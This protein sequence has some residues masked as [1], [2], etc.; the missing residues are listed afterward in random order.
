MTSPSPT[1]SSIRFSDRITRRA[2]SARP[3]QQT[4]WGERNA[5]VELIGDHVSH[6]A[7]EIGDHVAD[8][9][10]DLQRKIKALELGLA[11]ANGALD[12]L[13]GKGVPGLPNPRGTHDNKVIYSRLDIVTRDSSSFIALRDNP[14]ACPGDGWQMVACGGKKGPQGDRGPKGDKGDPPTFA[15]VGFSAD[16]IQLRTSAG[17]IPI[18]RSISVDPGDFSLKLVAPDGSTLRVSLLKLFREYDAQKQGV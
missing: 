1:D 13:K 5:M 12:I 4:D 6:L 18:L 15:G 10:T 17:A 9:E 14:G 3:A 16:G 8:L 7:K 2:S 11:Q